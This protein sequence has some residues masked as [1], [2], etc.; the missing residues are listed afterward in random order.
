M[1]TGY[2]PEEA[3]IVGNTCLYGATEGELLVRGKAGERFA[4]RNS[5]AE[6]VTEG[7]GDHCYEYMTGGCVPW[8]VNWEI[9]KM[10][11]VTTAS[12]QAQLR[13]LVQSYLD[14]TGKISPR[15]LGQ[16]YPTILAT[17]SSKRGINS[18]VHAS[19]LTTRISLTTF[20][21]Q[22]S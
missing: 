16:G 9:V 14:K 8:Q 17:G 7:T 22:R 1:I 11:R 13:K 5:M 21:Q 15:E 20:W 4:V 12:G 6:A 19:T 10:E 18:G 3:T 2:I